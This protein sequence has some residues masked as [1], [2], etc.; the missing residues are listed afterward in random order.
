[1]AARNYGNY[2]P[3]AQTLDA[4]GDR[5]ALLVIRELLAGPQRF[6]DLLGRL[7][8]IGTNQLATRLR[9]LESEHLVTKRTLPP[10]TP[11]TLYELTDE[12]RGL[13][14]A[15][16][17][18]VRF[19][20][21]RLRTLAPVNTFRPAWAVLALRALAATGQPP[22]QSHCWEVHVE[23][24]VFHIDAGTRGIATEPGPA[25]GPAT[26]I[27][28]DTITA[29]ALARR[30]ITPRQAIEQRLLRCADAAELQAWARLSGFTPDEQ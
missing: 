12:G 25:P 28:T 29:F 3:L 10:P 14:P 15:I 16:W 11:A 9:E 17:A 13:E 22:T 23:G 5:W 26:L 1:M 19:G 21:P 30:E 7:P 20:I 27:E 8:G 18:L 6:T 2:C 24:E 4:I